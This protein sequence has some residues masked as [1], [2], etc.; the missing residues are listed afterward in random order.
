MLA[1]GFLNCFRKQRLKAWLEQMHCRDPEAVCRLY[2]KRFRTYMEKAD[3]GPKNERIGFCLSIY[4]ALAAYELLL[5]RDFTVAEGIS[6]CEYLA[7]RARKLSAFLY[8]MADLLPNGYQ[9]VVKRTLKALQKPGSA[10]REID[11]VVADGRSLE[12][13]V[14]GCLYYEI[15]REHGCPELTQVFCS[16]SLNARGVLHRTARFERYG[17]LA[18]GDEYCHELFLRTGKG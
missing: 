3:F 17:T 4:S 11:I 6:A 2:E 1:A 12:Y 13:K 8:Y 14:C 9:I 15:C 5:E 7:A 10:R 18:D 16:R